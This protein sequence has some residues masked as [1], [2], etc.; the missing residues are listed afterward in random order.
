MIKKLVKY[1]KDVRT[2]MAKVSWPTRSELIGAS[3][4]V[5]GLSV[6]MA[7][8]VYTYDSVLRFVLGFALRIGQ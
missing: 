7:A 2:E 1:L 8:V 4:L 3:A 6:A 5:V